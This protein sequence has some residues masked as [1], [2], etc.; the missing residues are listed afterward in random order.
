MRALLVVIAVAS[1]ARADGTV[2]VGGSPRSIGRAGTGTVGDDGVGAL[3]RNPAA[4]ARRDGERA[5]LGLAFV[6]DGVEWRSDSAGAPIVGN[7]IGSLP[8]P[9]GG[10]EGSIGPWVIGIGAMTSAISDRQLRRVDPGSTGNTFDYRYTGI[11]GGVRRDTV[12]VGVARRI[13]DSLAVGLSIADSRVV[14]AETRRVWAG[15][16][17]VH[18]PGDP[19]DD[20]QLELTASDDF[21]PSAVG[22]LLFVPEGA[23]VE[24]G[25][26]V[27]WERDAHVAGSVGGFGTQNGPVVRIADPTA[28]ITIP[29]PLT[30][31]TGTRY[32]SDHVIAEVDGDLFVFPRSGDTNAWSLGD[33]EVTVGTAPDTRSTDMHALA[34]RLAPRTH[35]AARASVEVELLSGFLW[36]TAGYAYTTSGTPTAKWSPTLADLGGH[37][38]GFGLEGTAGSVTLTIGWSRTWTSATDVSNP[39]FQ[40]DNPF[41]GG[42]RAVPAGTFAS[43]TT[44][45]GVMLDVEK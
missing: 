33:V 42:D 18:A 43:T 31:R 41:P 4:M 44:Q 16:S 34:S 40:L 11:G 24:F 8:V 38:V 22:G 36:A 17:G 29:S 12:T 21:A 2:I 28:S 37:T 10:A 39:A 6:D 27:A 35:A 30:V 15:F 13:G 20:V 14:F 9:T 5:Q 1:A 26:S 23:P 7:Q 19:A 45:L 32:L 3:L 25:A